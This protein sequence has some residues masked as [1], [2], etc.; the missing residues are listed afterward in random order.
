MDAQTAAAAIGSP[1]GTV[2]AAFYF[3]PEAVA[4]ASTIGLDVVSLYAAGRGGVLGDR[5]PDEVDAVFFFF[6]SGMIAG[7]VES[8]RAKADPAAIVEAHIG[9]AADFAV[10]TFGSVDPAVLAAFADAGS[11]VVSELPSGRWPLVDGYRAVPTPAD[12]TARAYLVAV[13]LRELRGGIH[14][15]AVEAAGLTAAVSCQFDRGDDYYR[16]HGYGDE[17]RVP[18][19]PEVLA[20]RATAED[21]TD[22]M[23]GQLLTAID[24]TQAAELVA[25][26]E[27]MLAA[28]ATV[29][30][31]VS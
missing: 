26:A 19:T 16:L 17:D 30:L 20:A 6:K 13:L 18:E 12:P 24:G 1:L 31:P 27:A 21:E 4:R 22:R 10:A 7:V 29:T 2:G 9:S 15:E 11:R 25:G 28:G 5:T 14:R 8:A 23:M 3:S